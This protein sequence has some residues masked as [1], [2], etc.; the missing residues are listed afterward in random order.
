M[1][2]IMSM[3]MTVCVAMAVAVSIAM[4]VGLAGSR[5]NS[6]ILLQLLDASRMNRTRVSTG[7]LDAGV[8]QQFDDRLKVLL[9]SLW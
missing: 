8:R 7:S 6:S 5:A 3:F 4:R 2:V 9:G 1:S